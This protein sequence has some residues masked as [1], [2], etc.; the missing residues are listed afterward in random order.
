MGW[1]TV[2]KHYRI[3]HIVQ[4]RDG[5]ICIGS[6]Y[7]HNIIA[8]DTEGR[9]VK[10]YDGSNK[11]LQRYQAELLANPE[12]L[13]ELIA[14]PDS[15]EAAIPVYTFETRKGFIDEKLCEAPGY[16]NV[17]HDGLLMYENTFSTDKALVVRWAKD[18]A[19]R[20]I[21]AHQANIEE[22]RERIQQQADLLAEENAAQRQLQADYPDI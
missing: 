2:K 15:F 14:T 16:P 7:I 19:R 11:D 6:S 17:T 5:L 20:G 13:R 8:M 1:H 18:N 22:L 4:V 9:L 21:E 10:T 3:E 12:Q